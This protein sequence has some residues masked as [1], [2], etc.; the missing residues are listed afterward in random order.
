MS[1]QEYAAKPLTI[2]NLLDQMAVPYVVVGSWA[3]TIHGQAR[4]TNDVDFLAALEAR[5]VAGFVSAVAGDFYVDQGAVYRAVAASDSFNL[6]DYRDGFKI[7]VFVAGERPFARQQL[8]RRVAG[9]VSAQGEQ[10]LWILSPED[11]ILS[12]LDWFRRGGGVSERQWRDVLG[13][14]KVQGDAL[15]A[16]YLRTW[17]EEL[18]VGD[19]LTLALASLD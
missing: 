6:I 5:H 2:A 17:A 3:S 18:G 19:L 7:D 15:D 13:V 9:H 8:A 14:L 16:A 12:K 11:T 10:V 1:A 4:F